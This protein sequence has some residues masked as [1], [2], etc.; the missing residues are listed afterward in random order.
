M[1]H[2]LLIPHV[3][4]EL[5]VHLKLPHPPALMVVGALRPPEHRPRRAVMPVN[6]APSRHDRERRAVGAYEAGAEGLDRCVQEDRVPD[7]RGK[8]EWERWRGGEEK[9]VS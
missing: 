9:D 6:N 7:G 5:D 2:I 3:Q 8:L 4:Y 1:H